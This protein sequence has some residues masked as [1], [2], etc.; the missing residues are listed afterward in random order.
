MIPTQR[1]VSFNRGSGALMD[2]TL[3][4]KRIVC[5]SL[6][7]PRQQLFY[8]G[9]PMPLVNNN[10]SN[11]PV[12]DDIE[13]GGQAF[14]IK[15]RPTTERSPSSMLLEPPFSFNGSGIDPL[16]PPRWRQMKYVFNSVRRKRANPLH[17]QDMLVVSYEK[18]NKKSDIL[19]GVW[20]R[21]ES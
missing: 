10:H 16:S 7:E 5:P 9:R 8:L 13:S 3:M 19:S 15:L 6:E 2:S 1:K 4:T 14:V 12:V 17:H 21:R 18:M 11:L 20:R